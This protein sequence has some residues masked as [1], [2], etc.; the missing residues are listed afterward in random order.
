MPDNHRLNFHYVNSPERL[1]APAVRGETN[2][3]RWPQ[4]IETAARQLRE[5]AGAVAMIASA[6]MTNEELFLAAR[7]A[8]TLGITAVDVLPRPQLGDG[9]L[10]SN[11]GNPNTTGAKLLGLA[12]GQLPEIAAAV[13][14]G[15]IKALIVL[16]ED[17]TACGLSPADLAKLNAL[18]VTGI[19]PDATTAAATVLLP[20]ASWAEKRGSMITLK[21]RIQ[22][23]NQAV[24]SPGQAR[25]D[26]EI[27]RD[28]IVAAGGSNGVYTIED[29]FKQMAAE[30][31]AL[32]GLTLGRIGDLGTDLA[33]KL[34]PAAA[35]TR[36]AEAVSA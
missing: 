28:L 2:V 15:R 16:G 29:V 20:S 13:S 22:R 11:D 14:A 26:W 5:N 23:L 34:F 6:R 27:L 35:T 7:L 36:P 9:F 3:I 8:K 21:G 1:Q 18:I 32:S 17:A 33:D 19:L 24:A 4:A 12:T 10:I 30:V 31:P 25:D